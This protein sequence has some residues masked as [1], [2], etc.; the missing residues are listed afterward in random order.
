MA[1]MRQKSLAR[2]L[3]GER[4]TLTSQTLKGELRHAVILFPM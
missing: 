2:N 1:G 4:L 3:L